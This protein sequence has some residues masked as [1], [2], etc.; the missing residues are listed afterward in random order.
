MNIIDALVVTLELDPKKFTEGQKSAI[1]SLRQTER[2]ATQ[3]TGR[4]AQ[5]G[6]G[7]VTF[8]RAVESPVASLRQ[9]FERL[10]TAT[11]LPKQG[12]SDLAA[13]GRRT[14]A[15]IEAG[16]VAGAAGLRALGIAGI[17][18]FATIAALDKTMKSAGESARGVFSVGVSAAAAGMG[19]QRTSAIS[20]A[21]LKGG[22]VPEA[23]TQAWLADMRQ[24]QEHLK[25]TG[26]GAERL[27][28]LTQIGAG[29]AGMTDTPEQMMVK[30]AQAFAGLTDA[31]AIA[32]GALAQLSPAASLELKRQGAGLPASIDE[33]RRTAVTSQDSAAARDLIDAQNKL[34]V[35][36]GKLTRIIYDELDPAFTSLINTW[37]K[38]FDELVDLAKTGDFVFGRG[39]KGDEGNTWAKRLLPESMYNKLP[40]WLGG[41]GA[42]TPAAGG[43][44]S[45]ALVPEGAQE[46]DII[47]RESGGRSN[48]GY[49]GMAG[50]SGY[51]PGG[52]DLSGA[53]LDDTGFPIW[54]GRQG[55]AGISHAAGIYQFQPGTWRP[56]ARRLG[57]HDFS[58]ESQKR[59]HDELHRIDP[60][61]SA[62]RA[63]AGAS[64][65]GQASSPAA[66]D[67]RYLAQVM[68]RDFGM[69]A[70]ETNAW[71]N[72]QNAGNP[73]D[74]LTRHRRGAALPRIDLPTRG[75]IDA[76]RAAQRG[77]WSPRADRSAGDVTHNHHTTIG[78]V[79]VNTRATDPAGTGAA[80]HT[81]LKRLVTPANSG[82]T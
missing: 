77:D 22:N 43:S 8:F 64:R 10:A 23:E 53:P 62:W 44:S 7:L 24:W 75:S 70:E 36:W 3:S 67:N 51:T 40:R 21:L 2:Q 16:A 20:Q 52:V 47:R 11:V 80:V 15:G 4:I 33:A 35:S 48:V 71:S 39:P 58:P 28:P 1:E 78:D 73:Q 54:E 45:S 25:L 56:I 5:S 68:A 17:G 26:Q 29:I 60:S 69:T 82:L 49:G 63:S 38:A 81:A 41:P 55:P 72:D 12:L 31:E 76:L 18:A 37:T 61:D 6:S 79:T 50:T 30:M 13:Q 42:G 59:V 66:S 14:G 34:E 32:R 19:V 57:I 46:A 27:T 65:L 74:W 9:H